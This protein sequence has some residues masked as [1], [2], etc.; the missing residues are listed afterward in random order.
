MNK[1]ELK[2]LVKNYF[3][4]EDK[5]DIKTPDNVVEEKF[6]SGKLVD[7]TPITNDLDA[8]FEVGQEVYVT[9]EA[10]EKVLAPSGEHALDDGIVVV[11]DGEGKITGLHKPDE[12]G[13]G[14]LS[15]EEESSEETLAEVK[16]ETKEELDNEVVESGDLPMAEHEEEAE[17]DEHDSKMEIIEAIMEE[18]AP[19]I[20]EMQKKLAEHE[21]KMAEHDEKMKEHYSSAASESVTEKA[22][23]KA[24]YGSKPEGDLLTFD[25]STDLKKMQYENILSRASKNN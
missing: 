10:G 8:D 1:S 7:G 23:S 16:E 14:S 21:E 20:E 25:H 13:Q 19:K 9:T 2:D 24:G 17:M 15:K 3:S 5:K 11:V 12:T 6:Q 18:I 22:F 4:L